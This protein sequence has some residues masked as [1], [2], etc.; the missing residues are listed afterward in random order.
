MRG[1]AVVGNHVQG[2][3]QRPPCLGH[4]C[5]ALFRVL[6]FQGSFYKNLAV[7]PGIVMLQRSEITC[8]A[9]CPCN[10]VG[11]GI[12]ELFLNPIHQFAVYIVGEVPGTIGPGRIV[13][14]AETGR[15]FGH[16]GR[17]AAVRN[18][19]ERRFFTRLFAE[20]GF[21]I[22]PVGH[23][24]METVNLGRIE[25]P[26]FTDI[27]TPQFHLIQF[28]LIEFEFIHR[29]AALVV[30]FEKSLYHK[31]I[32]GGMVFLIAIPDKQGPQCQ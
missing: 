31:F 13:K 11:I 25:Q 8:L 2:F 24:F 3:S 14:M 17:V 19:F 32:E 16:I 15:H 5:V 30:L 12:G 18:P 22:Q 28:E 23:I 9:D 7:L 10:T 1:A 29:K 21:T 4:Q 20:D 27:V 6:F 26:G